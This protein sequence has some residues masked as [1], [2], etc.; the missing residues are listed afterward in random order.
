ML[1]AR[2]TTPEQVERIITTVTVP[3]R[4]R[5]YR[6]LCRLFTGSR[7]TPEREL[8]ADL[9]NCSSRADIAAAFTE[10]RFNPSIEWPV[11]GRLLLGKPSRA[12]A[13]KL[14]LQLK[15]ESYASR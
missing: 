13:E 4:L 10:Y 7:F 2:G 1:T 3:V 5:F 9:A 11:L 6:A 14:Y 8:V 15:S 12:R